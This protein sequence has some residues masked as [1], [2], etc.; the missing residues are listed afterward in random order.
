V[1]DGVFSKRAIFFFIKIKL[2][3]HP[4]NGVHKPKTFRRLSTRI[5]IMYEESKKYFRKKQ[6]VR[7]VNRYAQSKGDSLDSSC[8]LSVKALKMPVMEKKGT[9]KGQEG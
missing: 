6:V 3:R 7:H 2:S 1:K 8:T 5:L 4:N 9:R